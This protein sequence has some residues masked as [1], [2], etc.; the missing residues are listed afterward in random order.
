M[1][2]TG[3]TDRWVFQ[4]GETVDVRLSSVTPKVHWRLVRHL[5]AIS[6]PDDWSAHTQPV[7][8]FAGRLDEVGNH[9]IV[10]GSY[11][12]APVARRQMAAGYRLALTLFPTAFP[13]EGT[14][15]ASMHFSRGDV[16]LGVDAEGEFWIRAASRFKTAI[17]DVRL[18]LGSWQGLCWTLRAG[19]GRLSIAVDCDG[20]ETQIEIPQA[21]LLGDLERLCLAGDGRSGRY[22]GKMESPVLAALP[23]TGEQWRVISAWDFSSFALGSFVVPETTGKGEAG[24]FYNAPTRAVTSSTFRGRSCDFREAPR[25]YAAVWFHR[26]DLADAGWPS[27]LAIALP[28]LPSGIYSIVVSNGEQV[29]WHA[30]ETFDAIPLFVRPASASRAEVALILPTFSYRAYANNTFA[31]EADPVVFQRKK[32][33]VSKPLYDH[34]IDLGL[35]SLYDLHADR[36]GVALASLKR[37]QLTIRADFDSQLQGFPHQFSADLAIVDWLEREQVAYDVLTDETLHEEGAGSLSRYSV[38]LTGSHPEY[39]SAALLDAYQDYRVGGGSIMYLGGNGFYWSV[40]LS[41]EHPELLEVRRSEGTRT[42][43]ASVGERRQQLDGADGGIWRSLGRPPNASF[44]IGFCAHGFSGDGHYL[45]RRDVLVPDQFPRTA[46]FLSRQGDQP[47]GVAGLELDRFAPEFG[48]PVDVLVLASVASM[49]KGYL[50]TVEEFGG[51]DELIPDAGVALERKVRG[52]ITLMSSRDGGY[53]FSIGSIRWASGLLDGN[54][55]QGVCR[56]TGAV[57]RDLLDEAAG[58]RKNASAQRAHARPETR[59]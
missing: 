9:P 58:G 55:A 10:A 16:A 13:H 48:S 11:F 51:L 23:V 43:T 57:L 22:D 26:D 47:F 6:R 37:P 38:I 14:V 52:D 20:R 35:L 27:C 49:P 12:C 42:W 54:D 15:L 1:K 41:A 30:R 31:E 21:D 45:A 40:G 39:S 19:D 59:R 46:E 8:G 36:S 24:R 53:V 33:S 2:V 44:G 5:G 3:Y 7:P 32:T 29:D 17:P 34:A 4:S 56:L 25:D 28:D 18:V 50:P